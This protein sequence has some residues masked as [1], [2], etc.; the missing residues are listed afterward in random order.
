MSYLL[1]TLLLSWFLLKIYITKFSN[2]IISIP[3]SRSSH[4]ISTPSGGGLVFVILTTIFTSI[5]GNYISATTI[6]LPLTGL[7]DDIYELKSSVR[8]FAQII[9][10][11]LLI[12]FS[13][14]DSVLIDLIPKAIFPIV[15]FIIIIGGTAIINF[16]NFMDGTDGL[17]AACMSVLFAFHAYQMSSLFWILVGSLLGF[18]IWNW[19]PAKLFM[20]DVGSTFLGGV[21]FGI[22]INSNDIK[23]SLG[24]ILIASP[25]LMDA[26]ICIIRRLFFKQNIFTAHKSHLYQRLNQ[27]GWNHAKV[28]YLYTGSTILLA[29]SYITFGLVLLIPLSLVILFIGYFFDRMIAVPFKSTIKLIS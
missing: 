28:A 14:I 21:F 18:L 17:V 15:I 20:G 3:N 22:L 12:Y 25:L 11:I 27:S 13:S 29:V 9:T 10:V 8:Y 23:Y 1:I 4:E 6:L 26:L 2:I 19:Y 16:V 7:L 24:L 5:F